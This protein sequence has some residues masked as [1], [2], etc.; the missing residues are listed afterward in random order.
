MIRRNPHTAWRQAGPFTVLVPLE[1][2]DGEVYNNTLVLKGSGP[3]LWSLLEAPRALDELVE[4]LTR[5]Y[6][7]ETERAAEDVRRFVDFLLEWKALESV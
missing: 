5:E 6:A 1:R 7:V 4:G 2:M 3:F